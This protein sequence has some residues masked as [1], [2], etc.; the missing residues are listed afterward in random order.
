MKHEK[1]SRITSNYVNETSFAGSDQ[2]QKDTKISFEYFKATPTI[3]DK[4]VFL[5]IQIITEQHR[6]YIMSQAQ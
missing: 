6:W 1:F 3:H 5:G 4:F 2:S